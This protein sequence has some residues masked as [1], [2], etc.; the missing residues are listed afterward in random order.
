MEHLK[1][2][3]K[4]P[5][6]TNQNQSWFNDSL[7]SLSVISAFPI[8]GFVLVSPIHFV[9]ATLFMVFN[10]ILAIFTSVPG[11]LSRN[12]KI[13]NTASMFW[14]RFFFGW[15]HMGIA[16]GNILSFGYLS[17]SIYE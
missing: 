3:F 4:K 2:R 17:H 11:L 8:A 7:H 15:L 5:Q 9:L 14:K 6:K 10:F 16:L 12:Q 13:L 1:N